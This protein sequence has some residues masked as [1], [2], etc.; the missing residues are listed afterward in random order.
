[1]TIMKIKPLLL[2]FVLSITGGIALAGNDDPTPRKFEDVK[3]DAKVKQELAKRWRNYGAKD[4]M[5]VITKTV[6]TG[7]GGVKGCNTTVGPSAPAAPA[8]GSG[9]Y[10]PQ[11]KPS[12]TVVTGS[13]INVCR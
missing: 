2:A 3:D 7:P 4:E 11:P 12:I 13:V 8:A 6:N 9:R 5:N 1:M 10:G